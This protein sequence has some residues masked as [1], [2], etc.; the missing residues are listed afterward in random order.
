[1]WSASVFENL[2][3]KPTF[4]FIASGCGQQLIIGLFFDSAS[5]I[6]V[7]NMRANGTKGTKHPLKPTFLTFSQFFSQCGAMSQSSEKCE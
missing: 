6:N 3:I 4:L 7:I 2:H 5:D 1:M